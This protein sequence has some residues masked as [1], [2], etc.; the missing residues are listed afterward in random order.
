[1]ANNFKLDPTTGLFVTS[2]DQHPGSESDID[3]PMDQRFSDSL[4]DFDLPDA[5]AKPSIRDADAKPSIPA[6]ATISKK[7]LWTGE[8]LTKLASYVL[9]EE[10]KI[11]AKFQEQI[12]DD[13][14]RE[15]LPIAVAA[16]KHADFITSALED[17]VIKPKPIVAVNNNDVFVKLEITRQADARNRYAKICTEAYIL[18]DLFK[19]STKPGTADTAVELVN[20]MTTNWRAVQG[21][22]A[23]VLVSLARIDSEVRETNA[24]LWS[25][26]L[27]D[28]KSGVND[29]FVA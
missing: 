26:F 19:K 8:S 13:A 11:L 16:Q 4:S 29:D 17:I 20:K 6:V 25:T 2:V 23:A 22:R 1:M 5:V 14:R 28:V 15:N 3:E 18:K 10:E 27:E 21:K 7:R 12:F 9:K 24:M